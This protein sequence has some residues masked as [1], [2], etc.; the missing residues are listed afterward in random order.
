[1]HQHRHHLKP[2]QLLPCPQCPS[3]T[4]MPAPRG[5]G[6]RTTESGHRGRV[7]A[8]GRRYHTRTKHLHR[9]NVVLGAACLAPPSRRL[10]LCIIMGRG[11]TSSPTPSTAWIQHQDGRIRPPRKGTRLGPPLSPPWRRPD[12]CR[13]WRMA[14]AEA[15]SESSPRNTESDRWDRGATTGHHCHRLARGRRHP[16]DEPA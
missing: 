1:M 16:R 7:F 12:L 6:P 13:G 4:P 5:S 8:P 3:S 9:C 10:R 14:K 15:P 2:P 11:R